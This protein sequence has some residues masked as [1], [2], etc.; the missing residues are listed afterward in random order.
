MYSQ[1]EEYQQYVHCTGGMFVLIEQSHSNKSPVAKSPVAKSPIPK[2]PKY[3]GS[4][5]KKSSAELRKDYIAR[6]ASHTHYH[7]NTELESRIG[8]LWSWNYMLSKRWRSGNTGDE[9]FQDKVLKDFCAFCSNEENRL[10]EFWE[11]YHHPY[12]WGLLKGWSAWCLCV[13]RRGFNSWR[14]FKWNLWNDC[15]I[16]PWESVYETISIEFVLTKKLRA[17]KLKKKNTISWT[18]FFKNPSY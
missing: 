5:G 13:Y 6:Q 8:F 9:H 10:K 18:G 7:S 1:Y 16:W 2:E 4:L 15:F 14:H 3:S 11:E 12:S 17:I